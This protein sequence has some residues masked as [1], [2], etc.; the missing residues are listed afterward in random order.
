MT[1]I[2]EEEKMKEEKSEIQEWTEEDN[3]EMGNVADPYYEL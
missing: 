1:M 2:P 3:D